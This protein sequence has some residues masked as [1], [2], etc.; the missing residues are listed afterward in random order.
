[1]PALESVERGL[2]NRDYLLGLATRIG[3]RPLKVMADFEN[4]GVV[5]IIKNASLGLIEQLTRVGHFVLRP[6]ARS[7][8]FKNMHFLLRLRPD[9]CI[10]TRNIKSA[11]FVIK[12]F[13]DLF[14]QTLAA[15]THALFSKGF[16]I[17]LRLQFVTIGA[18]SIKQ[19]FDNT[20]AWA[21]KR[22]HSHCNCHL[23]HTMRKIDN[24]VR[25][26]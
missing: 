13:K 24:Y 20:T 17:V 22:M 7:I 25:L 11:L 4:L 16:L 5:R 26:V 14:R 12:E 3:R 1:M 10:I 18:P 19:L 15:W 8:F 9:V 23:M 21:K 6:M 2:R